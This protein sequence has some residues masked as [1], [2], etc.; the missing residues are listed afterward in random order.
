[1]S[2]TLGD[3]INKY[4]LFFPLGIAAR[5]S[6]VASALHSSF[7]NTNLATISWRFSTFVFPEA[8]EFVLSRNEW[9]KIIEQK[10][11]AFSK[12]SEIRK[13]SQKLKNNNETNQNNTISSKTTVS[14]IVQSLAINFMTVSGKINKD[15]VN[16]LFNVLDFFINDDTPD[17]LLEAVCAVISRIYPSFIRE[18][19]HFE[20]I[21]K[22]EKIE[23]NESFEDLKFLFDRDSLYSDLYSCTKGVLAILAPFI[24]TSNEDHV[25]KAHYEMIYHIKTSSPTSPVPKKSEV[26]S[27]LSAYQRLFFIDASQREKY[28]DLLTAI[29]SF[30]PQ[31]SILHVFYSWLFLNNITLTDLSIGKMLAPFVPQQTP[32]PSAAAVILS[33]FKQAPEEPKKKQTLPISSIKINDWVTAIGISLDMINRFEYAKKLSSIRDLFGELQA[34]IQKEETVP[35]KIN[36][37]VKYQ[38]QQIARVLHNEIFSEEIVTLEQC[39]SKINV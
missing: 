34:L 23:K 4:E 38:L 1:M 18:V 17:S 20:E 5:S 9:R 8:Q 7:S 36:R 22:D 35:D 26:E 11:L 6:L 16:S 10:R 3:F 27:I 13:K 12:I 19:E 33:A 30:C 24:D 39:L 21:C 14:K 37:V 31:S 32:Q 29:F 15:V 25:S 28:E 2:E